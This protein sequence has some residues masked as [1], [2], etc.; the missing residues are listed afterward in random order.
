LT[1][2][3]LTFINIS[4]F[5]MSL[6]LAKY[7][8]L[9][10]VACCYRWLFRPVRRLCGYVCS[11]YASATI[12]FLAWPES[13]LLGTRITTWDGERSPSDVAS[14]DKFRIKGV[15]SCLPERAPPAENYHMSVFGWHGSRQDPEGRA[16]LPFHLVRPNTNSQGIFEFARDALRIVPEDCN[17]LLASRKESRNVDKRRG[18]K[19]RVSKCASR[20]LISTP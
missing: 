7:L 8:A 5:S 20:C 15:S 14:R 2:S 9:Y 10:P 3:T 6:D 1:H 19:C 13:S 16:A 4:A 11:R 12:N 18:R 17:L